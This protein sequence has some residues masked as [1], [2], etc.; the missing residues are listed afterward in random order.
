M[1][2]FKHLSIIIFHVFLFSPENHRPP[3][4][5]LSPRQLAVSKGNVRAPLRLGHEDVRQAG[6]L[7]PGEPGFPMCGCSYE[8][9]D[10]P[11]PNMWVKTV[12]R[13]H[14]PSPDS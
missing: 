8:T 9:M 1:S 5:A 11:I 4:A 12:K 2:L 7:T 13:C 3:K 10:F 6:P 14:K